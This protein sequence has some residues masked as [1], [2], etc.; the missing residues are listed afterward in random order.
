MLFFQRS[1]EQFPDCLGEEEKH[2]ILQKITCSSSFRLTEPHL[3]VGEEEALT[4]LFLLLAS[5][6][7][8][9]NCVAVDAD[10]GISC[11]PVT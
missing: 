1:K 10:W 11:L 7:D 6:S 9:Y 2:S 4:T 8:G 5:A 3:S